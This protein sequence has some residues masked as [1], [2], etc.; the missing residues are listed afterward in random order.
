MGYDQNNFIPI[1]EDE[2]IKAIA[3]HMTGGKAAFRSGSVSGTQ[4]SAVVPDWHAAIGVNYG[5][6][7]DAFDWQ[8]VAPLKN[9]YKN[10][11]AAITGYVRQSLGEK[12]PQL[13][14]RP[15]SEVIAELRAIKNNPQISA[16]VK[17][18]TAK[19]GS[20]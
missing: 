15:Y 9:K 17:A 4:I 1:D 10:H 6:R 11:Q 2:L 16:G 5:H 20:K 14:E 18:L 12:K 7:F 19:M 3:C 13:L 8:E